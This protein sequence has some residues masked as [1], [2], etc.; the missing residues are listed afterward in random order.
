MFVLLLALGLAE[1]VS[2]A[3]KTTKV[4]KTAKE[5]QS[6]VTTKQLT[7]DMLRVLA[8]VEVDRI[9]DASAETDDLPGAMRQVADVISA[10]E[11]QIKTAT[12]AGRVVESRVRPA[13]LREQQQYSEETMVVDGVKYVRRLPIHKE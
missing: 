10:Y 5:A 2:E 4:D 3:D 1:K 9:F 7:R 11:E 6:D 8:H 13:P 12:P